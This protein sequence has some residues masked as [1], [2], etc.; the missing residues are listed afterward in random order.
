MIKVVLSTKRTL[1]ALVTVLMIAGLGCSGDSAASADPIVDDQN[2]VDTPT[3]AIGSET[4][5]AARDPAVLDRLPTKALPNELNPEQATEARSESQVEELWTSYLADS[6]VPVSLVNPALGDLHLCDAGVVAAR[7]V[8]LTKMPHFDQPNSWWIDR[9]AASPTSKWWEASLVIAL[10]PEVNPPADSVSVM[11]FIVEEGELRS[12]FH[13]SKTAI[14][15][16]ES[17]YCKQLAG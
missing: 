7:N 17:E 15:I 8:E 3:E 13:N 16:Y 14:P 12:N 9:N 5:D 11:T 4:H 1:I 6:L 2:Q 10:N